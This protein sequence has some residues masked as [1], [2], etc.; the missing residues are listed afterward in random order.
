MT[1]TDNILKRKS[2]KKYEIDLERY[3]IMCNAYLEHQEETEQYQK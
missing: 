3:A 1:F 2:Y